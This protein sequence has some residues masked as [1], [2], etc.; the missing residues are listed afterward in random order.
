MAKKAPGRIKTIWFIT[1]LIVITSAIYSGSLGNSFVFDD[2]LVITKNDFV[3]SWKNFPLIFS[4]AYLTSVGDV[5]SL[6][7]RNIGAGEI[8]YRPVVTASYF[9]DYSLWKLDPFGYHLVGLLLHILNVVLLYSSVFL[10]TK[11]RNLALLASLFFAL[12]PVNVEAVAV[13][14]FREDL[15][16]FFFFFLCLLLFIRADNHTGRKKAFYYAVSILSFL[17]ALFSKEMALTLPLILMLYDY[18]FVFGRRIKEV[19]KHIKSRYLGYIIALLFYSLVRFSFLHN[20]SEFNLKY[21]GDS[22]YTN[23]LVMAKVFAV[24][25]QWLL[26]PVN[27]HLMLP[28]DPAF[29]PKTLLAPAVLISFFILIACFSFALKVR[30]KSREISFAIIWIFITLL[31]VSNILPIRNYMASRYLYLPAAGFCLLLAVLLF[32]LP[33]SKILSLPRDILQRIAM[34]AV[35]ALL[36]FYSIFTLARQFTWKNDL[37]LWSEMAQIYP[38]SSMAHHNL[39]NTLKSIDL[40]DEA[41]QEYGIAIKLDPRYPNNYN[42]LGLCYYGK[43]RLDEAA[44]NFRKAIELNP[45]L[46]D[47]YI[48][49]GIVYG[50]KD[51]YKEAIDYFRQAIRIDPRHPQGYVDLGITYARMKRWPEAK[52]ALLKALE[53]NPEFKDA[54]D[55]L[56]KITKSGH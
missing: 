53:I 25:I 46:A 39:A 32:K 29:I 50:D 34:Y 4:K 1:L 54:R 21:P 44:K 22:F 19:Y 24:Y 26:F 10:I 47:A 56:E 2:G 13:I 14:S 8:G 42:F 51:L 38:K 48:N 28:G 18:F 35:V 36:A 9:L 11:K 30:E 41:I 20:A 45:K 52:E 5:T 12:H 33:G 31:P 6:G 15:L 23:I 17:L 37:V 16:S 27:I 55:N 3:K 49:L 7:L 40:L 43:G